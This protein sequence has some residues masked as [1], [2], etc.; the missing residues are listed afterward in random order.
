MIITCAIV[1]NNI[2]ICDDDTTI[3]IDSISYIE[4]VNFE[5]V[6]NSRVVLG[7]TGENNPMT[8]TTVKAVIIGV[9][10]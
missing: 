3:P 6:E 2:L 1:K 10:I 7:Y 5:L 8:G 4:S 9:I